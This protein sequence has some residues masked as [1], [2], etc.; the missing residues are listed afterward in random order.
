MK[1][2]T[3]R[4]NL[5]EKTLKAMISIYCRRQHAQDDRLCQ[6]CGNL[7]DYAL[8][9]L[10]RCPF[11]DKKPNCA[12]CPVHCYEPVMRAQAQKVM[13]HSGPLMIR[14]HPLLALIHISRRLLTKP[15]V[16]PKAKK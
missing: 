1:R 14:Y 4:F 3:F 11:G 16:K 5:E 13:R 12:Q 10:E 8:R 7:Q 15:P 9:R 6:D 2:G